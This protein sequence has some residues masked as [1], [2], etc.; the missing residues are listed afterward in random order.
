MEEINYKFE[1]KIDDINEAIEKKRKKWELD[2]LA[3]V[4]YDDVKQIIMT[5]IHKKWY[6][7]DQS[8]PIKPWLYRLVSNQFKNILRNYY[9][10]YARPCLRCKYNSGGDLCLKTPSGSQCGECPLYRDWE[11]CKKRAYDIKLPVT[12]E[13]HQ[14]EIY[15]KQDN[16]IDLDEATRKLSL[17]MENRLSKKQFIAFRMLF[18]ENNSEEEVAKFLGY[19]TNEKKRTAGYKQIK[20]LRKI[21]QEK[22]A[23]ILKDIDI[24]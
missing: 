7:W 19:K 1:D 21:F 24:C 8:R 10:N 4:D 3:S 14:Y 13:N 20:N 22:A 15:T 6:L 11:N 12:I 23:Q 9:G 5:H 17:E 2:A 18:I 16:Y